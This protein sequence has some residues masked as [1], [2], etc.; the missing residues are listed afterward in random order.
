MKRRRAKRH[1]QAAWRLLLAVALVF[2]TGA[3]AEVLASA[4]DGGCDHDRVEAMA[5]ADHGG[6]NTGHD[7]GNHGG[8][9]GCVNGSSTCGAACA[10]T[11]GSGWQ[12]GVMSDP[13]RAALPASASPVFHAGHSA[14]PPALLP[15]LRPPIFA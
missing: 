2:S 7:C 8:T 13:Y 4:L 6:T 10:A 3:W 14:V 9:S 11:C 12:G 5:H 1:L 15:A